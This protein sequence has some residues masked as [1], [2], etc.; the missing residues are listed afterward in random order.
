MPLNNEQ[1]AKLRET[2]ES[3]AD[4]IKNPEM[5]HDCVQPIALDRR[6]VIE[7]LKADPDAWTSLLPD[8]DVASRG[9]QTAV[10]P[11]VRL[12]WA[13]LRKLIL[14]LE[15]VST[16]FVDSCSLLLCVCGPSQSRSCRDQDREDIEMTFAL[17]ARIPNFDP[18]CV[19][20]LVDFA[21]AAP[22]ASAESHRLVADATALRELCLEMTPLETYTL[23][24][25]TLRLRTGVVPLN[26]HTLGD[27]PNKGEIQAYV[28]SFVQQRIR[29]AEAR[30]IVKTGEAGAARQGK[31][32]V[33]DDFKR[34]DPDASG[35]ADGIFVNSA[36]D[37]ASTVAR[38]FKEESAGSGLGLETD[39]DAHDWTHHMRTLLDGCVPA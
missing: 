20:E 29:Q 10:P 27:R 24:R 1:R 36:T 12:A 16:F 21:W 4:S 25:K 8:A 18:Y 30:R 22:Q 7:N 13:E 37:Y 33:K 11:K 6:Q 5:L 9:M 35:Y 14:G 38:L 28:K 32:E 26:L 17:L 2:L 23:G 15:Y 3:L 31:A 19:A 39:N 34:R